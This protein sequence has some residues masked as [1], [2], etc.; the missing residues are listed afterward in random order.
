MGSRPHRPDLQRDRSN[1]EEV[2]AWQS[3]PLEEMYPI[4]YLDAMMAKI[5]DSGHVQNQAASTH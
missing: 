5:R 3:R 4:V 1:L 2:K